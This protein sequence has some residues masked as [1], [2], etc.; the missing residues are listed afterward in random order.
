MLALLA[1]SPWAE[2]E[3]PFVFYNKT[4]AEKPCNDVNFRQGLYRAMEKAGVSREG[5]RLDFHS[6]RHTAGT[7]LLD[8]TGDLRKTGQIL[9]H[10]DL[11]MTARYCDHESAE[12]I[13]EMGKQAANILSFPAIEEA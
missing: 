8:A 5:R 9:G 3:N 11:K 4:S 1:E 10:K 2:N 7:Y 12:I 6:L 13:E